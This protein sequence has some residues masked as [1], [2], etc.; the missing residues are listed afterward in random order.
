MGGYSRPGSLLARMT[1]N[2]AS[3]Q[4]VDAVGQLDLGNLAAAMQP[5][6]MVAQ[7]EHVGFVLSGTL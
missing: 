3:H 6:H 1:S 5:F 4:L 2:V 7:A